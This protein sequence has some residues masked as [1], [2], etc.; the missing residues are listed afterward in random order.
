AVALS[1]MGAS[2]RTANFVV[3]APSQEFAQQV[4]TSAEKFRR[5]LA[6]LWLGKELPRWARPC[7]ITLPIGPHLGAGGAPSFVFDHGEV[8]NWQMQIQGTPERILDSVLPHE[9]T[10]TIFASHFR[11]PLPRWADEGACTTVEH[12]SERGKQSRLLVDFLQT[13]RGIAFNQ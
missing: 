12:A 3:S 7:P 13:G 1:S 8:F 9:I 10:H 11:Q 2:H 6:I 5:E 4:G